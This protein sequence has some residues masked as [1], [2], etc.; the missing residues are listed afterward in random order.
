MHIWLIIKIIGAIYL[1]SG[2]CFATYQ[3]LWFK[4]AQDIGELAGY[5][6]ANLMTLLT[7]PRFLKR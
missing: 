4:R 1:I 3:G 5:T 7:W 6:V 2:A